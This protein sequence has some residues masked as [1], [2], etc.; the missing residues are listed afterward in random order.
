MPAGDHDDDSE[1]DGLLTDEDLRSA[2]GPLLWAVHPRLKARMKSLGL[3]WSLWTLGGLPYKTDKC[4][5]YLFF[6][7]SF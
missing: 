6:F 4:L 3:G 1:A 7:L 5:L 2:L